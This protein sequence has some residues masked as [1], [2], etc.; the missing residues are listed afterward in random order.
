MD[1]LKVRKQLLTQM[2][3]GLL[4]L[5]ALACQN[6]KPA[7][8]IN[9]A[10]PETKR[11]VTKESRQEK[12]NEATESASPDVLMLGQSA[13]DF[14]AP[15]GSLR[16]LLGSR[17]GTYYRL[18]CALAREAKDLDLGVQPLPSFG[19]VENLYLVALGQ[20]D[21]AFVQ[22]D[23]LRNGRHQLAADSVDIL[24]PLFLEEIHL[25]AKRASGIRTV[26][27]LKGKRVHFGRQGSGTA[28]TAD[29]LMTA[30]GLQ[31]ATDCEAYYGASAQ[32]LIDLS[33]GKV[34]AA[35]VVAGAPLG[36]FR[37]LPPSEE[38]GGELTLVPLSGPAIEQALKRLPGYQS[39]EVDAANYVWLGESVKTVAVPCVLI[40]SKSM[41]AEKRR[42]L[43]K[44]IQGRNWLA[45]A[46]PK[47]ADFGSLSLPE[48]SAKGVV[49]PYQVPEIKRIVG[50]V[51]G[52]T[53]DTIASGI[54]RVAKEQ[55]IKL[56]SMKSNG[57]FHNLILL[58][59][60]EADIALVQ[61]DVL[62]AVSDSKAF[63]P[64]LKDVR[65]LSPVFQEEV[66]LLARRDGTVKSLADLKGKRVQVGLSSSG[67]WWTARRILSARSLQI[68]P[69]RS[70]AQAALMKVL[71]GE[72]DAMF[73]VGG[74]P[75]SVLADLPESYREDLSLLPLP[76][77]KGY[78]ET[79]LRSSSYR[80]S[81]GETKS[82]GTEAFLI[83]RR[84]LS[85]D[86]VVKLIQ[87]LHMHRLSLMTMHPKWSE[88][89]LKKAEQLS[90]K[91]EFLSP[92]VALKMALEGSKPNSATKQ[93]WSMA[94]SENSEL[95][96]SDATEKAME[97]EVK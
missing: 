94:D 85:G 20:A 28:F 89:N 17:D 56:S 96:P 97:G 61:R 40:V 7:K 58:A 60:G 86:F 45:K 13:D 38:A 77:L 1:I 88:L 46:H 19:S 82:V 66:H 87:G 11:S 44:A 50:A 25:V 84:E 33:L 76:P 31:V 2:G 69:Q 9:Q 16:L 54:C 8:S 65:L 18:G 23:L 74:A 70:T 47:G 71:G 51:E 5:S 30:S 92:H 34:D 57:S 22:V 79:S 24:S 81:E 32:S 62:R 12:T 83:G 37:D 26:A 55:S 42:L 59:S 78:E 68:D 39:S 6:S 43:K 4:C 3:L 52:G 64:L 75:M 27:D 14:E 53:Y 72:F 80:W 49:K 29:S 10:S 15:P 95:M 21:A 93:D 91:K 48:K 67:T 90:I 36:A 63:A 73:L 35:W 41:A